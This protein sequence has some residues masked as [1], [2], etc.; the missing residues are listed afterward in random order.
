MD[1]L[2]TTLGC[3]C[4]LGCVCEHLAHGR[5]YRIRGTLGSEMLPH[6][7]RGGRD[8]MIA[9]ELDGHHRRRLA[10]NPRHIHLAVGRYLDVDPAELRPVRSVSVVEGSLDP[11][12]TVREPFG[13]F[14]ERVSGTNH[15]TG[16]LPFSCGRLLDGS[17]GWRGGIGSPVVR[18][19]LGK[20]T[21]QTLVSRLN[22]AALSAR[23]PIMLPVEQIA[24]VAPLRTAATVLDGRP[25]RWGVDA[26]QVVW[27]L[28]A[29]GGVR[30]P[31]QLRAQG[32]V[33]VLIAV[34]GSRTNV[35]HE[36][37]HHLRPVQWGVGPARSRQA[38]IRMRTTLTAR[39]IRLTRHLR[40]SVIL[41]RQ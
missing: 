35:G 2:T 16:N 19:V 12:A 41:S 3:V 24:M 20:A 32:A 11:A 1:Q 14:G 15:L 40:D 38:R 36:L 37:A 27:V 29:V 10:T 5:R 17:V 23:R 8:D 18:I 22:V 13:G 7:G 6:R 26:D 39:V 30:R 34:M 31:L 28:C 4:A 25:G 9:F 33:R 21:R